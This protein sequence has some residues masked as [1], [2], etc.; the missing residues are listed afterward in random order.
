MANSLK[1]IL[2]WL[3]VWALL[4]P[5][6]VLLKYRKQPHYLTPVIIYLFLALI[7]NLLENISWKFK[8]LYDFPVWFQTNTYFYTIHS[9]VR[10]LLLGW[11]FILLHQPFLQK[12]KKIILVLFLIFTLINFMFEPFVNYWYEKGKLQSTLSYKVLATEAAIMLFYCLQYYLYKLMQD[13]EEF[14]RPSDFWVVTGLSIFS[15][16]SFPIY[17]FYN[18]IL[19]YD[20][21]FTKNIWMVQKVCFLIFCLCIAWAFP[22]S[23]HSNNNAVSTN[24]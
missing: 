2:D 10:V 13:E 18:A 22:I 11:F 23:K 20:R 24:K 3:E 6:F 14:K 9:I 5:L 17:F 7:I 19:Q 4:I 21:T 16:C 8:K 1:Q 15:F 12:V